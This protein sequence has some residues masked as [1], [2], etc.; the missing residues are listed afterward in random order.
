M[1]GRIPALLL[2][3]AIPFAAFARQSP[4][5]AKDDPEVR[6]AREAHEEMLKSGL[7]LVT[8]ADLLGRVERIGNKLAAIANKQ[9]I[10]ATYGAENRTAFEYKFHVVDD[11]DVNAFALPAGFI[12][13]N[14]GLL[15]YVQ[16]DDELAGVL[17]HEIMHAAHHHVLRLQKEQEKMNT[18]LALGAIAAILARVPAADTGNLVTGL[19]LVA[20]QKVNGYSQQAERDADLAGLELARQSGYNI[21]GALTFMERLARDQRTRPDVDLGIFRTHPPEKQRVATLLGKIKE[22]GVPVERRRTTQM[23]KVAVAPAKDVPAT[24][25][26]VDGKLILRTRDANRARSVADALD[27]ALDGEIQMYELGRRDGALTIRGAVILRADP[28]DDAPDPLR[29]ESIVERALK[30]LQSALY[31]YALDGHL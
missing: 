12:Y 22:L 26:L 14:K 18:Q 2:L 20:L 16:S 30:S 9:P 8:D 4:P 15:K 31:R 29:R 13:V 5:P 28:A 27:K 7:K 1:M 24:E 25:V 6:I 10:P 21:V 17:G 3:L 23:L 11:P 19:Q